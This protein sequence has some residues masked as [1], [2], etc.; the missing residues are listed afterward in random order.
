VD[1]EKEERPERDPAGGERAGE[2][3]VGIKEARSA[4][5]APYGSG[6]RA[7]APRSPLL[8]SPVASP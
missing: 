4:G 2:I 3:R 1:R 5:K 6:R 8:A 7:Y